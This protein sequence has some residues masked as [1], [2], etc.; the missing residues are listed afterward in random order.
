MSSPASLPSPRIENSP[1]FL[2][3]GF[4]QRYTLDTRKDIP[5][6]WQR[7]VPYLGST[8]AR[9]GHI[10]YGFCLNRIDSPLSFEYMA[11]FAVSSTENLP[12]GFDH[13]SVPP[14]RFAVFAHTGH[15]S[16]ISQTIDAIMHWLPTSGHRPIAIAKYVPY[17]IERY[18]EKFDPIKEM[19]DIEIRIPISAD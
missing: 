6:L 3:A 9:V 19:G 10:A 17:L 5:A 12:S 2:A 8:P 18:G 4:K 7:L 14:M 13:V 1:G 11:A 16:Q 15:V